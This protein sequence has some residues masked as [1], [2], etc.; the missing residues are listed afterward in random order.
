MLNFKSGVPVV[1]EVIVDR[2]LFVE[3]PA[4]QHSDDIGGKRLWLKV[5]T[6]VFED[7]KRIPILYALFFACER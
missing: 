4:S 5:K 1:T 2:G 3:Y 7:Q 6:Q